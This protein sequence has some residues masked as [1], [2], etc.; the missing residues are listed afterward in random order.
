MGERGALSGGEHVADAEPDAAVDEVGLWG[1]D[2]VA[3]A[4]AG[5]AGFG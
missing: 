2:E 5:G 3:G 1:E 4:D